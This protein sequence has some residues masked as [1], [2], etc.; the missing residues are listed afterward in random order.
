MAIGQ[1]HLHYRG[2]ANARS[3]RLPQLLF[4]LVAVGLFL[5]STQ[6]KPR[7]A[8]PSHG[9]GLQLQLRLAAMEEELQRE[10]S[11]V[12]WGK[13]QGEEVLRLSG[14]RDALKE[15]VAHLEAVLRDGQPRSGGQ[16]PPLPFATQPPLQMPAWT[17]DHRFY[18]LGAV[19]T[20]DQVQ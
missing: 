16:G 20:R 18:A 8:V 5:L 14:E 7:A 2:G 9:D 6:L 1:H 17:L 11:R 15:Q 13:E 3:P 10:H 4:L 19:L 12:Q